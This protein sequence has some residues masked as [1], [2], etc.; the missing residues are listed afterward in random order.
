MSAGTHLYIAEFKFFH[1]PVDI[2]QYF[3]AVFFLKKKFKKTIS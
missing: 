1:G 2:T 3:C